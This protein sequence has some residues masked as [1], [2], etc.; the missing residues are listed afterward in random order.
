[1]PKQALEYALELY[2]KRDDLYMDL[3]HDEL[4]KK[5]HEFVAYCQELADNPAMRQVLPDFLMNLADDDDSRQLLRMGQYIALLTQDD[6]LWWKIRDAGANKAF[7]ML[8]EE[9]QKWIINLY[10][11]TNKF[12]N[13]VF[14]LIRNNYYKEYLDNLINQLRQKEGEGRYDY[15]ET[16]AQWHVESLYPEMLTAFGEETTLYNKGRLA[17]QLLPAP[18]PEVWQVIQD[19]ATNEDSYVAHPKAELLCAYGS[20]SD[21]SHIQRF[22]KNAWDIPGYILYVAQQLGDLGYAGGFNT[23]YQMLDHPD[24]DVREK[25]HRLMLNFFDKKD[26]NL[27]DAWALLDEETDGKTFQRYWSGKAA[28]A[29]K[30]LD[31]ELHYWN[32]KP[33][34]LLAFAEYWEDSSTIGMLD[35]AVTNL[36]IWTGGEFPFDPNAL[37]ERQFAQYEAMKDWLRDN[38]ERFPPGHWYR[39]GE[40]L[41][42]KPV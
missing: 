32:G 20:P 42:N 21:F 12:P 25:F 33:F 8:T 35:H 14:Y 4:I 38:R 3:K 23:Y 39:W 37:Y 11:A 10:I 19:L 9:E 18:L 24:W 6:A 36:R 26:P 7:S 34:D 15:Y 30:T 28:Y 29:N 22:L 40:R 27:E 41:P 17:Y 16:L 13:R 5:E 31:P 1:M 2:N